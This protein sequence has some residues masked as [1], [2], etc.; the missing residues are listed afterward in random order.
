MHYQDFTCS[1]S[2]VVCVF[3]AS[4]ASRL[5]RKVDGHR[6]NSPRPPGIRQPGNMAGKSA[7]SL[8]TLKEIQ[9]RREERERERRGGYIFNQ[10]LIAYT[11]VAHVQVL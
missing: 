10:T 3:G 1:Q 5:S 4:P 9:V 6:N 11:S 2:S 7:V 8:S